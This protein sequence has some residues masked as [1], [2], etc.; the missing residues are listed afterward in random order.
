MPGM[1]G[2]NNRDVTLII[3][4]MDEYMGGTNAMEA[5]VFPPKINVSPAQTLSAA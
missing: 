2:V 5:D 1:R 3:E 4:W